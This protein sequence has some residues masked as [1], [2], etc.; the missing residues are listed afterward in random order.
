M[1]D[2]F[3]PRISWIF[4]A[5]NKIFEEVAK[6]R[7]ARKVWAEI[8]RERFE[9]KDPRSWMLRFHTQTSGISL[10]AQ[11]SENNMVRVAYQT[12]AAVLGGAQSIAAC[13]YD[14]ALALPTGK[15]VRQNPA[16][17]VKRSRSDGYGGSAWEFLLCGSPHPKND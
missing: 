14:E 7:A 15:S 13:S 17:P 16:D 12:L 9:A 8:L 4:N 2:S 1:F 10:R 5:H 11:Q 6:Y 3:A